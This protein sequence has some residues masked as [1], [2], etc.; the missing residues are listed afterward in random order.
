MWRVVTILLQN[1][2]I[3]KGSSAHYLSLKW[4]GGRRMFQSSVGWAG[5]PRSK[6]GV[7]HAGGGSILPSV[8]TYPFP[9]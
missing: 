5:P 7:G 2:S 8:Y 3:S 1:F 6:I 9:V 4:K